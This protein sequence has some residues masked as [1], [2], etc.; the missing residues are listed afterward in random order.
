M[1]DVPVTIDDT[2]VYLLSYPALCFFLSSSKLRYP[3]CNSA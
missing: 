2:D 3:P 1:I